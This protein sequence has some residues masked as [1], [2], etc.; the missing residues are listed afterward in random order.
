MTDPCSPNFEGR[1]PAC[2]TRSSDGSE[3]SQ[4]PGP[5][6]TSEREYEGARV[7]EGTALEQ[8]LWTETRD[9]SGE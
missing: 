3:F 9:V 1:T 4:T 8:M 5:M 7:L 6:R 2:R